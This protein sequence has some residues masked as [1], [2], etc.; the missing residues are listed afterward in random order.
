[1][2]R[3][4]TFSATVCTLT[5]ALFALVAGQGA[6]PDGFTQGAQIAPLTIGSAI[7]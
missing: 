1:M 4:L 6:A 5:L 3:Q 2:S 7:E